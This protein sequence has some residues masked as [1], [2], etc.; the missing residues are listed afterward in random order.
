VIKKRRP[1]FVSLWLLTA[2]SSMDA[3][4]QQ[5]NAVIMLA[6]N[7]GYPSA[8]ADGAGLQ[9]RLMPDASQ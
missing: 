1:W 2:T 4:Q 3:Q 8:G 6:D 7:V 9:V 5:L